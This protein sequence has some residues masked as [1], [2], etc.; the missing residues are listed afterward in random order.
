LKQA[1]Y[2]LRIP[3]P[4]FIRGQTLGTIQRIDYRNRINDLRIRYEDGRQIDLP[5][6]VDISE[7]LEESH[8]FIVE[9][10][11]PDRFFV[12]GGE[13]A[14]WLSTDL[15]EVARLDLFRETGLEEYWTTIVLQQP[16][17]LIFIYE[18][19]VLVID[20]RLQ[21]LMHQEKLINDF[22]VAI[23]DNALKFARDH[24]EEWLMALA[25]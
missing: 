3:Q 19:G 23:E 24:D 22:F 13:L 17:A 15:V 12:F 18:N 20:K 6:A 11:D 5:S 8:V 4:F 21:V 2:R 14:F 16:Q 25:L 7:Q 9:G 10:D 1:R